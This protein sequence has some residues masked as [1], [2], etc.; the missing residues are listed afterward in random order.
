MSKKLLFLYITSSFLVVLTLIIIGLT[1][2]VIFGGLN[3]NFLE[4][5]L[6]SYLKNEH[7][8]ILKSDD[9]ILRHGQDN[10]LYIDVSKADLSLSDK[11]LLTI[12]QIRIDF[13]LN[14]LFFNNED[15]SITVTIDEIAIKSVQ[16]SNEIV[17]QDN[18]VT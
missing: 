12:N 9:Y 8:I 7:K 1:A 4:Q 15:Q 13:D 14:D 16:L 2:K 3:I 18:F 17:L 5:R 6:S 10:G 11:T